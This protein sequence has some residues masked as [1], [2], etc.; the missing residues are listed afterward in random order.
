MSVESNFAIS[1]VLHCCALL[2]AKE[3][4]VTFSTN[5]EQNQ[6]QLLFA[7]THFPALG[8]GYMYLFRV[9]IGSLNCLR[10]L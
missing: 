10:L 9:L 1:L 7:R 2:L 4:R 6:N 5:Q 8:G 3:S